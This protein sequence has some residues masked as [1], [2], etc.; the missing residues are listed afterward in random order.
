VGSRSFQ[1]NDGYEEVI[2]RKVINWINSA[3]PAK[4]VT[5]F[6]SYK[7]PVKLKLTMSNGDVAV[8]E[9]RLKAFICLVGN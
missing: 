9:R 4:G 6:E 2:I 7:S 5:G 1:I 3:R 8:I